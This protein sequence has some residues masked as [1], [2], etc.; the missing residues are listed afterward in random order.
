MDR[1]TLTGVL[2][3]SKRFS[4]YSEVGDLLTPGSEVETEVN[5]EK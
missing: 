2:L 4:H 3:R 5:Q 1:K